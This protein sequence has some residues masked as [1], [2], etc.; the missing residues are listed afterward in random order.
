MGYNAD[1]YVVDPNAMGKQGIEALHANGKKVVCYVDVGS[2]EPWRADADSFDADCICG[3]GL[4]L[5][6]DGTCPGD[7]HKMSGWDEWWFNLHDTKCAQS[8]GAGMYKR[9]ENARALGCDAIEP[10]N[11][12]ACQNEDAPEPRAPA[13]VLP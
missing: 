3:D 2:W 8:V 10:D 12:D 1:V 4:S 5:Q 13:G 7:N 11:I 6:T 9:F